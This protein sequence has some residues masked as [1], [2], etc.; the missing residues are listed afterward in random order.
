M[1]GAVELQHLRNGPNFS[2]D[3]KRSTF[4][5]NEV[6]SSQTGDCSAAAAVGV[7]EKRAAQQQNGTEWHA[8]R[9]RLAN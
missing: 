8:L 3:K 2:C 1:T 4:E 5:L 6:L 7:I 9:A